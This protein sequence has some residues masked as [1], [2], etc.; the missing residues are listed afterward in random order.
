MCISYRCVRG[1]LYTKYIHKTSRDSMHHTS[2]H[3]HIYIMMIY[4]I[5]LYS[6][7]EARKEL[8]EV[9]KTCRESLLPLGKSIE[10]G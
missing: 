1:L 4:Q 3:L 8:P 6:V 7:G 10:K 5:D 2:H 9:T